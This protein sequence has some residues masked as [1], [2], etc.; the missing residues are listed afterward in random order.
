MRNA[1][2]NKHEKFYS[3]YVR[4]HRTRGTSMFSACQS[5]HH[6]S[7][8]VYL[9]RYSY[10]RRFLPKRIIASRRKPRP[11]GVPLLNIIP[12]DCG[13]L[14]LTFLYASEAFALPRGCH[15]V[16]L[17]VHDTR[18]FPRHAVYRRR[19]GPVCDW[20]RKLCDGGVEICSVDL[21]EVCESMYCS[22]V[23]VARPTKR[24]LQF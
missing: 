12:R 5:I 2:S 14:V 8:S 9:T 7:C 13:G 23:R 3:N 20:L 6:A 4:E 15:A 10:F 24:S 16:R 11:K 21:G 19:Y 1:S 17:L 22:T 18:V